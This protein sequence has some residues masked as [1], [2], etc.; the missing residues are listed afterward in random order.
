MKQAA[1]INRFLNCGECGRASNLEIRRLGPSRIG[2]V[3]Y[4]NMLYA[5]YNEGADEVV[6]FS[7]WKATTPKV[8][9]HVL[10]IEA[11]A[12]SVETSQRTESGTPLVDW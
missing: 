5:A 3:G 11:Q 2:L 1:L 4:E 7:D 6:I 8:K 9:K 12:E 10:T